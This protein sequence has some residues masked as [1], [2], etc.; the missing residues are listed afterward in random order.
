MC[1]HDVRKSGESSYLNNPLVNRSA[2]LYKFLFIQTTH[3]PGLQGNIRGHGLVF[4]PLSD[5]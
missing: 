4:I 1:S 3:L 5:G 2:A